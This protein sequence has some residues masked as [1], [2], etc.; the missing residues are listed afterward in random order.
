MWEGLLAGPLS[1]CLRDSSLVVR[2]IALDVMATLG[3]DTLKQLNVRT[4]F[5]FCTSFLA[6]TPSQIHNTPNPSMH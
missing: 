1:L 4:M 2:S 6:A 5:Y 3:D